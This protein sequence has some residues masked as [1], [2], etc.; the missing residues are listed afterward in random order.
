MRRRGGVSRRDFL[1]AAAGFGRL[2]SAAA[3]ARAAAVAVTFRKPSPYEALRR[4]IEPGADGFAGEKEAMEIAALL[5]RLPQ[6][7]ALPLAE[8]FRGFSPKPV[9][10]EP[11]APGVARAVYSDTQELGFADALAAWL[12]ALGRIRTVRFYPLAKRQVRFEISSAEGEKL[13][14]RTGLW[15][16]EWE[17]GRLARFRPLE[18]VLVTA[19]GPLFE[20]VTARLFGGDATFRRQL[21]RGVPYWRS[22]LDVASGIDIYGNNGISAGDVDNDGWDEIFVAQPG[23][24]PN[25]LYKRR[26]DGTFE[27][28]TASSPDLAVLDDTTGAL[29]LDLRNIGVQDLVVLTVSG[30]L[31]FLNDGR[32]RFRYREGAFRARTEP[33]GTFTG[34]AAADYDRDGKLDLYLCTYVYFQSEDQ[35]RYPVPYH[36]AQNGP[37]NFLFRNALTADGGGYFEDVTEPAGLG[38]NNNRYSF[39]PAWCD[40]DGDGWPDLYVANDFGRNN[41][42]KNEKGKFRDIAEEAGVV[43]LGPGMSAAWFDFDGDGLADLYVSNMWTPAG[44]RVIHEPAFRPVARDGLL[45]AY[46]RHSKGSSLFRN[47]GDGTFEEVGAREHVEMARW[48]WSADGIDF[49]NDGVPEI[50]ATAGMLTNGR[51]TDLMS[52]FW[53][54]VIAESPPDYSPAP[55][56]ENGWNAINQFIREGYSWEG[57]EPNVF[58]VRRA[59]RYYDFSGVSGLDIAE[60]S[61]AFAAVDLDGDGAL[62]LVVKNRLGP[63]VR[64]FLNQSAGGRR[65]LAVELQGTESNRDAIGARVEVEHDG[66]RVVRW[67]SAGSGYLSQHTKRLYFGLGSSRVARLV[68]VRWPSGREQEFRNLEAG[69][70]YRIVEGSPAVERAPFLG[71][72]PLPAPRPLAADNGEVFEPTWLLEP[73]PLPEARKGP[74]FLCLVNGES[75]PAPDGLPFEVVDLARGAPEQRAAYALFRRY[76]FDYRADL[77]TPLVLL[78]DEL[79]RAHKVY[80]SIPEAAALREDL[81]RMRASDRLKL[82]LPFPGWYHAGGSRNHFRLG[83]AFFWAGYPEQGLPY[84]EEALRKNPDN[85]VVRL[86]AGQILLEL[87]RLA[88][89]RPHLE[90]AA[91]L[92][93]DNPVVWNNMGGV[94][95]AEG[96]PRLA[97]EHF[98]RALRLKPDLAYVLAN[99]AQACARLGQI[100]RAEQMLRRALEADPEDADSANQLG[101]LAA[102]AGRTE[103]AREL[104]QRAIRIRRDHAGAINNLGVLYAQARKLN[105]A[106][107]AFEYGVQVAPD[108]ERLYLN[109]ARL[110]RGMGEPEKA[111]SVL[112]RLRERRPDSAAAKKAL[113]ELEGSR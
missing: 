18:E 50:Y 21:T 55:E 45:E 75:A 60:D 30:P 6:Q 82:A 66:G 27:D 19:D 54:H 34:L 93:P 74:G 105:D 101:L 69:Y 112:E 38:Q 40:F 8:G 41:L 62:D 48:S 51:S 94:A 58:Y 91:A 98:E 42:Y 26:D 92:K 109:L 97:L 113:E 28:I 49:D 23:G 85:A 13:H 104:F 2:G 73:V 72:R 52:F 111:R 86:A 44:I 68:K 61:R 64:A 56:Y 108:D 15:E 79:G 84:L 76:L 46:R 110:Y 100:E 57:R 31:L 90:R 37:P 77:E 80:P 107:A 10:Y 33:K 83:A 39:A 35:Y 106:V 102:K 29:F 25:R 99:A 4:H 12:D 24:L 81:E 78:I 103:E 43:D 16:M 87:G 89:A 95:M 9:R 20:D 14:Y 36:D 1:G 7:R 65:S 11:V 3:P 67:L 17:R 88:E 63:Q 71:R 59:G 5:S 96:N 22:R 47:R 32:G 70:R 53:R